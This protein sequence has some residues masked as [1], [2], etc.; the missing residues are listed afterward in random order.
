MDDFQGIEMVAGK[1]FTC[2][3]SRRQAEVL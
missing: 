2:P 3:F 1:P